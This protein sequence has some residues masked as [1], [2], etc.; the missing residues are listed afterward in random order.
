MLL[1]ELRE[2][3]GGQR[4]ARRE[5]VVSY[6]IAPIFCEDISPLGE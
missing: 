6:I 4:T 1:D 3:P 5:P 2:R